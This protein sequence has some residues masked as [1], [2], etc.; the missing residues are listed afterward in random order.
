MSAEASNIIKCLN[1][2]TLSVQ[3]LRK[4]L[5][6]Q[7]FNENFDLIASYD[8]HFLEITIRYL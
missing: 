7:G 6:H 2:A 4:A 1:N 5:Y 3:G 8:M